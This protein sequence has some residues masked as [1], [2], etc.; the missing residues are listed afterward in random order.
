MKY[1][2]TK[3]FYYI[4]K[5]LQKSYDYQIYSQYRNKYKIDKTF[6]FNGS[7]IILIGDGVIHFGKNSYI[8]RNS[9]VQSLDGQSIFIGNNVS[10]GKNFSAYTVNRL[11]NQDMSV[12][13]PISERGDI[14][15]NDNVWIGHN[16]YVRQG[17][18]IGENSVIAANSVVTKNIPPYSIAGGAPAKI[19]KYKDCKKEMKINE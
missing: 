13:K 9:D 19:I 12:E 2:I 15:I 18:V 14:T 11:A 7:G 17:I 6:I 10:I 4:Y 1:I 5:I 8:G 16:V 3:F